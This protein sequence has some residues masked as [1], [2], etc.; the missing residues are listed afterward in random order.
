MIYH[1]KDT[2]EMFRYQAHSQLVDDVLLMIEDAIKHG[3]FWKEAREHVKRD[4]IEMII[5]REPRLW[6]ALIYRSGIIYPNTD[7]D[8]IHGIALYYDDDKN[9]TIGTAIRENGMSGG[10]S[11]YNGQIHT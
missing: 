5:N 10:I 4:H 11:L 9:D 1:D 8:L 7:T 2:A 3:D 6:K